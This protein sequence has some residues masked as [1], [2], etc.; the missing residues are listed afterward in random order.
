[1]LEARGRER[2]ALRLLSRSVQRHRADGRIVR[3]LRMLEG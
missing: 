2:A 1:M 3:A